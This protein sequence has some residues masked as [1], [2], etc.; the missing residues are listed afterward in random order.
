MIVFGYLSI[1][2]W[3][4]ID[5]TDSG[6]D[7]TNQWLIFNGGIENQLDMI[8]GSVFIGGLWNQIVDGNYLIWAYLGSVLINSLSALLVFLILSSYFNK[9][10]VFLSILAITPLVIVPIIKVM[11]YNDIPLLLFLLMSYT[12]NK[13]ICTNNSKLSKTLY[14]FSGIIYATVLVSRFML[15]TF[16]LFPIILVIYNYFFKDYKIVWLKKSLLFVLGILIGLSIIFYLLY[17]SNLLYI[18]IDNIYN[19]IF[20]GFIGGSQEASA[21]AITSEHNANNLIIV[22]LTY[23]YYSLILIPL[24][25]L[26]FYAT[27]FIKKIKNNIIKYTTVVLYCGLIAFL[28]YNIF[29]VYTYNTYI[30]YLIFGLNLIL[31][32]VYIYKHRK[33]NTEIAKRIN[34]ILLLAFFSQL[35]LN[36]GS[37]ALNWT[38]MYLSTSLSIVLLFKLD[39]EKFSNIFIPIKSFINI[40]KIFVI[41]II[42]LGLIINFNNVYRDGPSRFKLIHELNAAN[43]KYIYTTRERAEMLD[44]VL[45]IIREKT[46]PRDKIFCVNGINMVYYLTETRP[47]TK[48]PWAYRLATYESFEEELYNIPQQELPEI[49][50]IGKKA[51][52][53]RDPDERLE[54]VYKFMDNKGYYLYWEND[55]FELYELK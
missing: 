14:I 48:D 36:F 11:N 15:I 12:I 9:K 51:I 5:F 46:E 28:T 54:L 55:G 19:Q 3:Q 38:N 6:W 1:W 13:A 25:F 43:L 44:G 10:L 22:S 18:Y 39:H 42:I 34:F 32:I 26:F 16:L 27:S 17:R 35:I 20:R 8:F 41:I 33:E 45:T 4:G 30:Y 40:K 52:V 47:V 2:I 23:L 50:I 37:L 24:A 7:L 53:K 21:I 49:V 29:R 31:I